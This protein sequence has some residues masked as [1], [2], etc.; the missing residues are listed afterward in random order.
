[1]KENFNSDKF[2]WLL[3]QADVLK[4]KAS[5]LEGKHTF[6]EWLNIFINK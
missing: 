5:V 4:E 2:K 6:F 1:M 3:E